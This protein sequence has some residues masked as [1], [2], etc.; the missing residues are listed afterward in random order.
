MVFDPIG[1][2]ENIVDGLKPITLIPDGGAAVAGI[3]SLRRAVTHKEAAAS[4][5][6]YTTSDTVFH[7]STV[8]YADRLPLG[9]H[10]EEANGDRWTV[11]EHAY[12]TLLAR[13][14]Y[15]VRRL[16]TGVDANNPSTVFRELATFVK[17]AS[18]ALEPNWVRDADPMAV[19]FEPIE[20]S[21]RTENGITH[22]PSRY[23]G[24]F[25][26][27]F[28]IS[29]RVRFVDAATNVIYKP[30]KAINREKLGELFAV[31]CEVTRW[32]LS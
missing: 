29:S 12:Q 14:R 17:S 11:L 23:V 32:P 13:W 4:N 19:R 27:E 3:T 5:G 6:R 1:D 8:D 20:D 18:G 30:I 22:F 21:R 25:E 10:I 7:V 9:S 31:D 2:F 28:E 24:H 15:I 16:D 26:T